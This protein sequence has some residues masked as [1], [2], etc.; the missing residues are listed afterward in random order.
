MRLHPTAWRGGGVA[1]RIVGWFLAIALPIAIAL[2]PFS[3]ERSLGIIATSLVVVLAAWL[4]LVLVRLLRTGPID[5][6]WGALLAIATFAGTFALALPAKGFAAFLAA[7]L[8]STILLGGGL[9][10]LRTHGFTWWRATAA[11]LGGVAF[12]SIAIALLLPGWSEHDA[13]TWQPQHVAALD[14]PNPGDKGSL[15]VHTLTYGS[16]TDP[17]RPEY[18]ANVDIVTEPVDGSLLIDGWSGPAGWLRTQYWGVDAKHLPRQGRVWFPDGDGPFPLVL[19]VHGNHDMEDFS[20]VG[21]GY[22]GELFAGRGIITVSVDENFLNSSF[23]D[24]LGGLKGGLKKENDARAWLLLE[25]LRLWRQWNLD[26]QSRFYGK[27]DMNRVAL[28]GHSRG[29]EAVAIAALFNKLPYFPDDA[30]IKFDYNFGLRGVIA[31]APSDGQYEPRSQET[32]LTDVNY[33]VIQGSKDGDVQSFMGSSQYSRISFDKCTDCFKAGLYLVG[34]N[35]GQF[36][37]AWGRN[38]LGDAAGALLNLA[39]IMDADTQRR[40]AEV[41]FGAFFEVVLHERNEYRGFLANPASG[42]AW[43]PPVQF[44]NQYA[45]AN[46][47][48]IANFEEDDDLTTGSSPGVRITAVDLARWH[49]IQVPLKWDDLDSEAALIGWNRTDDAVVPELHIDVEQAQIPGGQLSFSLAM[50]NASPLDDEDAKWTPPESIDFHILVTDRDGHDASVAL[51]SVQPLYPAISGTPRKFAFL[52]GVDSSEPIFQRYSIPFDRFV[53]VDP[54]RLATIR[55]RFDVTPAG[56]LYLD[57]VA[58][59]PV[60]SP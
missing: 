51:S 32:E 52:D 55:F 2:R 44:I 5:F 40:V 31:I 54:T 15:P 46:E 39:P 7:V 53:G 20:D 24:L 14:L 35:H 6:W 1:L 17:Q 28:I 43:L 49:E 11:A 8:A 41:V 25:H 48:P 56:A 50:A 34:A 22:L 47:T 18:G 21:Y 36:N 13:T 38:D 16:G 60:V 3:W 57:D 27:I 42:I 37:T 29:G 58:A 19:I 59:A 26:P 10:M 33:L 23:A 30:R 4:A 9:A 12:L 45:A